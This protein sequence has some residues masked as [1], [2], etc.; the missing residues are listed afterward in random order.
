MRT[1]PELR[2]KGC[3]T[4]VA[5]VGDLGARVHCLEEAR[6][7]KTGLQNETAGRGDGDRTRMQELRGLI[8][9]VTEAKYEEDQWLALD[10]IDEWLYEHRHVYDVARSARDFIEMGKKDQFDPN[11]EMVTNAL[12]WV[13]MNICPMLEKI[14][15]EGSSPTD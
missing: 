4:G 11:E 3:A 14:L 12:L 1:E 2:R 8:A 13:W 5:L 9:K 6:N 10:E 7:V 15:E